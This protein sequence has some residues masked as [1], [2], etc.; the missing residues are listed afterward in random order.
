MHNTVRRTPIPCYLH[1]CSCKV[2]TCLCKRKK[3]VVNVEF[4]INFVFVFFTKFRVNIY[5]IYSNSSAVY[6]IFCSVI[7]IT[8]FKPRPVWVADNQ[9]QMYIKGDSLP[10]R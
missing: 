6:E 5:N 8:N 3:W 10:R 9:Q 7:V 2:I 4:E 1:F